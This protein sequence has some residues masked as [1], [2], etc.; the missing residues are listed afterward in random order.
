[1]AVVP[2]VQ[3]GHS[4]IQAG[5][6]IAQAVAALGASALRS[7]R[8]LEGPTPPS[9][10]S[11]YAASAREGSPQAA[12]VEASSYEVYNADLQY[13]VVFSDDRLPFANLSYGVNTTQILTANQS[14]L[15]VSDRCQPL[16][17]ADGFADMWSWV[18]LATFQ[19]NT[20]VDNRACGLW[21]LDIPAKSTTLGLCVDSATKRLPVALNITM[22][23]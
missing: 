7:H 6:H 13:H 4:V 12:V 10:A 11:H 8:P 14:Y 19:G 5:Q 3:A 15:V 2:G 9:I 22:P 1:M 18:Q 17:K 20:T 16:P 21:T 23:G